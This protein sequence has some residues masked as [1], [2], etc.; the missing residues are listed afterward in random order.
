MSVMVSVICLAYNHEK[1]I[2]K[3]LEGFVMQKTSFSVEFI[4]HDDASTDSTASIIREFEKK[5]PDL[6]KPIYQ[7][8]NQYSKG[9]AIARNLQMEAKGKYMAFCEGD[10]YWIDEHKLQKQIE[11]MESHPNCT[12]TIHNG[13]RLNDRTG[14]FKRLD[15]YAKTGFLTMNDVLVETGEMTPTASMV[16]RSCV[17]KKMPMDVFR[18]PGVG[19]RPRRL[20]LAT[21]GEVFYFEDIMCVYRTDNSSSFGGTI[22]RDSKKSKQLLSDMLDF[23]DR[24]DNYTNYAYT[25]YI[26]LAKSKE[27]YLYYVR[28]RKYN[29]AAKTIYYNKV[30]SGK[31]KIKDFIKWRT[32]RPILDIANK[33]IGRIKS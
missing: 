6:I 13:L 22:L 1:Y 8:E 14:Q 12:L 19:D 4:V 30:T 21:Q 2:K 26:D 32:P 31:N 17:L 3:T 18:V 16:I 27:Y 15:P 24:F 23:F 9:V 28:E 11:F 10:D 25:S 5:Y 29:E 20:Y 7:K 33:I